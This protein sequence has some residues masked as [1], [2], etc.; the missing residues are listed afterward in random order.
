MKFPFV[1]RSQ[2]DEMVEDLRRQIADQQQELHR[3]K[4]R[5]F[6]EIWGIQLHD[7]LPKAEAQTSAPAEPEV[8]EEARDLDKEADQ[9]ELRTIRRLRPSQL[10]PALERRM[11]KK[12]HDMALAAL[13][14]RTQ[15]G[16]PANPAREIFAKAKKEALPN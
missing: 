8:E 13:P 6:Q 7:S 4:D 16:Q 14:P 1:L 2:H 11:V 3:L 10:G 9:R 5:I 12:V 15:P